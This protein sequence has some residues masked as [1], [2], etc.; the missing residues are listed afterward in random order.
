MARR[1]G[2]MRRIFPDATM[3]VKSGVETSSTAGVRIIE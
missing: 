2:G 1:T 3:G